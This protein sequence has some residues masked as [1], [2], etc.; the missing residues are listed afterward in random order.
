[1]GYYVR[2]IRST[3]VIPKAALP[4]VYQKMCA[5]NTTH[6]DQKHGGRWSGNEKVESWFS[7]MDSDYDVTCKDACEIFEMLGFEV[8]YDAAGNLE[9]LGYDDKTGQEGL[10]LDAIK[11]DGFGVIEWLGEGGDIYKTEFL[12]DTV[13]DEAPS[14]LLTLDE[15]KILSGVTESGQFG[16][17]QA[18]DMYSDVRRIAE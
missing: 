1:M 3:A 7:W 5:L 4:T 2:I 6:H 17:E 16:L 15:E 11:Y 12:G 14:A 10:F 18:K 8:E 13:V 9:I